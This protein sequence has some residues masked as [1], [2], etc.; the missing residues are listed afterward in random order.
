MK[1]IVLLLFLTQGNILLADS[2]PG[3]AFDAFS[4][5]CCK[6]YNGIKIPGY[7]V[8]A[9]N[10]SGFPSKKCPCMK[11]IQK[12][13]I[14]KEIARDKCCLVLALGEGK[15]DKHTVKMCHKRKL[16]RNDCIKANLK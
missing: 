12:I 16:T 13:Q 15:G 6:V 10:N 14:I 11:N 1:F 8:E 5:L 2:D 9:C 3:I 7:S 4:R